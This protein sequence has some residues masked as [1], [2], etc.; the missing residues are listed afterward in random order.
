MKDEIGR[1]F[2][3]RL[4]QR[5]AV[6]KLHGVDAGAVQHQSE[7]LPDAGIFVDHVTERGAARSKRWRLDDVGG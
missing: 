4:A 3:H 5:R 7:E 6:G 2:V 1:A